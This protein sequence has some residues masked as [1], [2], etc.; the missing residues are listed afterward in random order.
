MNGNLGERSAKSKGKGRMHE[1]DSRSYCCRGWG[2]CRM[3]VAKLD[4]RE[5]RRDG[6]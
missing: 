1:A 5:Q 4:V 2:A 3:P 6:L